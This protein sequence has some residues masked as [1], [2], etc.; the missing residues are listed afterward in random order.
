MFFV[1]AETRQVICFI[2]T[3]IYPFWGQIHQLWKLIDSLDYQVSAWVSWLID[4]SYI[5]EDFVV[6]MRSANKNKL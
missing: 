2:S 5:S 1:V 4:L 3:S 6:C